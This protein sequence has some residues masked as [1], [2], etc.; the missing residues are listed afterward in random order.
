MTKVLLSISLVC[1]L[2]ILAGCS[3]ENEEEQSGVKSL[4]ELHLETSAAGLHAC[5]TK[6]CEV[7]PKYTNSIQIYDGTG[8]YRIVPKNE[9]LTYRVPAGEEPTPD[10]HKVTDVLK[11]TVVGKVIK[12]EYILPEVAIE[13]VTFTVYDKNGRSTDFTVFETDGPRWV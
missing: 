4:V 9:Y 8:D 2:T 1:A 5:R 7:A 3:K 13:K 11:V 10:K 12:I 6:D